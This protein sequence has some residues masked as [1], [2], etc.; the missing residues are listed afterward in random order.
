[1]PKKPSKGGR[2]PEKEAW[3][4]EA[5]GLFSLELPVYDNLG[6]SASKPEVLIEVDRF[7]IAV[8]QK[9]WESLDEEA[10]GPQSRCCQW[11][12]HRP[13]NKENHDEGDDAAP[14][15]GWHRPGLHLRTSW[16]TPK[17]QCILVNQMAP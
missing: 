4:G 6:C 5:T 15:P 9:W 10:P 3:D 12:N 2:G 11:D 13:R 7:C 14:V 8:P 1:M 17:H 16:E